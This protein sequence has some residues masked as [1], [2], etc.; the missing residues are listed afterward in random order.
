MYTVAVS[1]KQAEAIEY[2]TSQFEREEIVS[3][4]VKYKWEQ[5]ETKCLNY[6]SLDDLIIAIYCGKKEKN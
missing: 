4:H 6:M 3:S 5:E 1:E 2:L